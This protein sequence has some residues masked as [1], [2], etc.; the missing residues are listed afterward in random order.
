[1]ATVEPGEPAE[2]GVRTKWWVWEAPED[3]RYTW[4]LTDPGGLSLF[5]RFPTHSRL[6]V[7]VFTGSSV[8]DLHLVAESR[9]DADP[10]DFVFQAAAGQRYWIAAGFPTGDLSAYSI[11]GAAARYCLGTHSRQR[12]L[13]PAQSRFR[14]PSGSTTG[15]NRFATMEPSERIGPLGRSSLWWQY[16]APASGWYRF[17]I[18]EPFA[19][20]V[21]AVYRETL[22][23]LGPLEFVRSSHQPE[24][25]ESYAIELVFFAEAGTGYRIRLGSRGGDSGGEFTLH[26]EKS[27]APVWLKF[28]ESLADGDLDAQGTPVALRGP[29]GLALNG[30]GTVLYVASR[31]GLQ[32]F[33]RDPGTGNLT[34]LQE[35]GDYD[36]EDSSLIWDRHRAALYVHRCGAWRRLAA[37]DGSHRQLRDEG[38]LSVTDLTG[39]PNCSGDVFMDSGG[40]FIHTV[41]PMQGQLQVL[42]FDS[43]SDLRHVQTTSVPGL[44]RALISNGGG[45]L[46]A[47][48]RSSVLVFE[49][50][51]ETGEL[52]RAGET[53]PGL[54]NL[55]SIAISSDDRYLFAFDDN[56]TRSNLFQLED[57]PASPRPGR[58]PAAILVP[59][60][61]VLRLRQP[62]RRDGKKGKTGGRP[63]LRNGRRQGAARGPRARG[64]R[65][66]QGHATSR[67]PAHSAQ[68]PGP[69]AGA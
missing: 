5:A 24:G 48:T 60:S 1:M 6:R 4:S 25:L 52:T 36:L 58:Q 11:A 18:D 13:L 35:M 65:G 41:D 27:E 17:R 16:Q 39:A 67:Q 68:K 15:S 62:L 19:P 61:G 26:W 50:N 2:S 64:R 57:D 40:S 10:S 29:A 34:L 7:T 56:G 47:A 53:E 8:E 21:L 33:E 23:G 45:H 31:L 38:M 37:T 3:G 55:Q 14:E 32:V 46:Y 12:P 22:R 43:P 59:A 51:G 30:R 42:A 20:W 63:V 9:M 66:R 54:R 49:R 69:R 44:R 28:V